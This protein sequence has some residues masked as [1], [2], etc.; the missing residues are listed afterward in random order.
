MAEIAEMHYYVG[1][2]AYCGGIFCVL[3]W[4]STTVVG[5][6][7]CCGGTFYILWRILWSLLDLYIFPMISY[8]PSTQN[9]I[10]VHVCHSSACRLPNVI[11][12]IIE[13]KTHCFFDMTEFFSGVCT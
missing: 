10:V 12:F 13:Q 7:A 8:L 4:I 1:I 9:T 5:Y 11:L 2:F 3:W 6:Y